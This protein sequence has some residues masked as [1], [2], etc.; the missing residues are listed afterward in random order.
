MNQLG[1]LSCDFRTIS[2]RHLL[3]LTEIL[4]EEEISSSPDWNPQFI[5]KQSQSLDTENLNRYVTRKRAK[6]PR[7][8]GGRNS[9]INFPI[10]DSYSSQ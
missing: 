6:R 1:F 7:N 2:H 3:F 5:P 4:T 10:P 9:T 8:P